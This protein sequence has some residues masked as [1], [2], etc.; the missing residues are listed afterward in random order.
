VDKHAVVECGSHG[1]SHAAFVCTH[2]FSEPGQKWYRDYPGKNNPSPDAWC[3]ACEH[4]FEQEGG[5]SEVAS[6]FADIKLIC[7]QC[8]VD[9]LAL[10]IPVLEQQVRSEWDSFV[11][12]CRD[13]LTVLQPLLDSQFGIGAFE[14]YDYDQANKQLVFSNHGVP[15]VVAD[16][17]VVG[18]HS[19]VSGTWMWSW[20]NFSMLPKV[21]TRMK[22]VRTLGEEH[23]FPRLTTHLW[24]ADEC[25]AWNMAA[26]AA[27]V[28]KA[29]G[30]Y[31]SPGKSSDMYMVL[32]KIRRAD[33]SKPALR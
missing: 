11:A 4:M 25:D 3:S 17:E 14:R 30:V 22:R 1:P 19:R 10:S 9:K 32:S 7:G 5:W 2:L 6:D 33:G 12:S 31:R 18:T 13:E 27:H 23:A 28:L 26:I 20:A 16:F 21:R 15:G 24:P 29:K 8:Y